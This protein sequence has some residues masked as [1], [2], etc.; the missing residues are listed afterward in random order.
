MVT[1]PGD[2]GSIEGLDSGG[3]AMRQ[4][5]IRT[6]IKRVELDEE[7]VRIIFKVN[8]SPPVD[9]PTRGGL[10]GVHSRCGLP[11]RRAA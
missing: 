9:D 8:V 11:A 5:I 10:H 2:P 6:L 4:E 3:F 1:L 7:T